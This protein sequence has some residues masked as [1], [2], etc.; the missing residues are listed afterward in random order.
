M[1]PSAVYARF[2]G[3]D[4]VVTP[5]LAATH[6]QAG[7]SVGTFTSRNIERPR[8][9]LRVCLQMPVCIGN[10]R[11]D[12]PNLTGSAI[13]ALPPCGL[14]NT[15]RHAPRLDESKTENQPWVIGRAFSEISRRV[16]FFGRRTNGGFPGEPRNPN[17]PGLDSPSP[18]VSVQICYQSNINVPTPHRGRCAAS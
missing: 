4:W 12:E 6:D 13:C 2:R 5:P 17:R 10:F 9:R 7:L 1:V 16:D 14:E 3:S 8:Q 18:S 15:V 11:S